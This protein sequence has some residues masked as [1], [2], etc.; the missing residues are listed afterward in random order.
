VKREEE[1]ST[2]VGKLPPANQNTFSIK[3]LTERGS[4]RVVDGTSVLELVY[5]QI[6]ACSHPTEDPS[7]SFGNNI[8]NSIFDNDFFS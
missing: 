5:T 8:C 3:F 6:F 7:T 4:V 1:E 2:F